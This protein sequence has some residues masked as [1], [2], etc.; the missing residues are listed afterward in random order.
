MAGMTGG[1]VA[2]VVTNPIEMV[3]AR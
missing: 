1:F 2:G 3:F